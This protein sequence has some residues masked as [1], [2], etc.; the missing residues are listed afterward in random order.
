RQEQPSWGTPTVIS[1]AS[2]DEL[3]T[4]ASKY[5]RAYDPRTGKE[6]WRLG[7]SSN[8]AA[9][10]PFLA[11]GLIVVASGRRPERPIFAV[12]PGAR[13]DL[14]L[15][16]EKTSSAAVVWSKTGRGPYMP[17]PLAYDGILYSVNNDGVFDAYD[18]QTGQEIYRQRLDPIG[19]G[20]SASPVA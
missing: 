8:I 14:T 12:R 10:T 6:L 16:R 9:P 19:S 3:V 1:S 17:T 4:N 5:I 20:F 11:G 13:G 15:P 18:M 2:G 7:G